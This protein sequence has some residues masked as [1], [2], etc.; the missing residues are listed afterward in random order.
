MKT[1]HYKTTTHISRLSY[2]TNICCESLRSLLIVIP[3]SLMDDNGDNE[4]L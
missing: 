3:R 4:E 2:T 1:F